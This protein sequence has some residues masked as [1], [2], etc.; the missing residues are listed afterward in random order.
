[1]KKVADSLFT[2]EGS[3]YSLMLENSGNVQWCYEGLCYKLEIASVETDKINITKTVI[4]RNTRE[5][6]EKTIH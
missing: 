5:V 3:L 6:V 1:M 4:N 2:N